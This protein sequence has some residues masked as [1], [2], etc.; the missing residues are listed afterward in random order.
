M[1]P[2]NDDPSQCTAIKPTMFMPA[3][4]AEKILWSPPFEDP[5]R[6]PHDESPSGDAATTSA[7]PP[8]FVFPDEILSE[9]RALTSYAFSHVVQMAGVEVH[10][11]D[12][13]KAKLHCQPISLYYPHHGCHDIIDSMVKSLAHDQGADVVVLDSLEL[14]L[15]EFGVFGKGALLFN[16]FDSAYLTHSVLLL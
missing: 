9:A 1:V 5:R 11:N 10:D 14:A 16:T 2:L 12:A 7:S 6:Q 13:Q 3:G 8:S 4:L 15:Q